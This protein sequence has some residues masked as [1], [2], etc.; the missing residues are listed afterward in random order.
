M[1]RS[2]RCSTAASTAFRAA[3]PSFRPLS[4]PRRTFGAVA[5]SMAD[6]LRVNVGIRDGVGNTLM[7]KV[8][9]TDR[10]SDALR[11]LNVAK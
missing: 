10:V 2:L 8:G 11:L 6:S 5:I 7:A 1:L 3:P 4:A 9:L